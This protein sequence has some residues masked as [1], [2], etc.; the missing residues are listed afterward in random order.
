MKYILNLNADFCDPREEM[1]IL[2]NYV[3]T[4]KD[5]TDVFAPLVGFFVGMYLKFCFFERDSFHY[6]GLHYYCCYVLT[7]AILRFFFVV[8]C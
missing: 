8:Y 7:L 5:P 2:Q 6:Q 3:L 4:Y 1:D